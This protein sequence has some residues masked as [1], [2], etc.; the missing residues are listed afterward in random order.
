[1]WKKLSRPT[2][3]QKHKKISVISVQDKDVCG[4]PKPEEIRSRLN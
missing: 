4:S 1:M 3:V 2:I